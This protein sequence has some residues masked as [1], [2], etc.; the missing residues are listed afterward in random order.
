MTDGCVHLIYN[1]SWKFHLHAHSWTAP[2]RA[3]GTIRKR[4]AVRPFHHAQ[5]HTC[6]VAFFQPARRA[7][8]S[9]QPTSLRPH[10]LET[11]PTRTSTG[12][13]I[14]RS[15]LTSETFSLIFPRSAELSLSSKPQDTVQVCKIPRGYKYI[16]LKPH[17]N[18]RPQVFAT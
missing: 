2:V 11:P 13:E 3:T 12:V 14:A 4:Q 17:K 7:A 5:N 1:C 6:L 15:W 10:W 8:V 16:S 18:A 9:G